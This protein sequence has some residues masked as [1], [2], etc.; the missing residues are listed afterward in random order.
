MVNSRGPY[1]V[2]VLLLL[3][4]GCT[5]DTA[6]EFKPA[7]CDTLTRTYTIDVAP[8]MNTN[9]AISSCHDAASMANGI[10]LDGFIDVVNT[11]NSPSVDF[12]CAIKHEG[13]CFPMPKGAAKLPDNVV[14]ML[15]CWVKNGMPQ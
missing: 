11:I 9:C 3:A 6:R 14:N 8:I 2:L 10:R 5:K 1:T 15:D 7:L 13:T 4:V 12:L